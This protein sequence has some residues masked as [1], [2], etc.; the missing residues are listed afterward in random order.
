M[1]ILKSNQVPE[2]SKILDNMAGSIDYIDSFSIEHEQIDNFTIDYLTALLFMTEP[3]TWMKALIKFRNSIAKISGL[4]TGLTEKQTSF[5][6]SI[7]FSTGD[8]IGFFPVI[9]HSENEIVLSESDKH[10]SFRASVMRQDNGP[11]TTQLNITT[12][13]HYNNIWGKIY[14]IP[15]KTFHQLIVK[16]KIISLSKRITGLA[17]ARR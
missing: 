15:V 5:D 14:F 2:N 17:E 6:Q 12:I 8:K 13:V 16:N 1:E 7:T 3:P 4:K 11:K 9:G 10:L